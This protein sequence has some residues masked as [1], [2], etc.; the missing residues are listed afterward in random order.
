[1]DG[2]SSENAPLPVP[3]IDDALSTPD[4]PST[5]S[6]E[7]SLVAIEEVLSEVELALSRLDRG[8]YGRCASCEEPIDDTL[9]VRVPTLAVCPDC[10]TAGS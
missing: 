4:E 8:T 7:D 3:A 2:E 6:P 1:M 10:A 5:A 9:L